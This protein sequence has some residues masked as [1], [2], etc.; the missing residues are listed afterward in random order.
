MCI[1]VT[2]PYKPASQ[3][4]KLISSTRKK[5]IIVG[6]KKKQTTKKKATMLNVKKAKK[7]TTKNTT[8]LPARKNVVPQKLDQN[9]IFLL[10]NLKRF[11]RKCIWKLLF[12]ALF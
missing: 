8:K 9:M 11:N 7:A 6:V 2:V 3:T 4:K 10:Q 1:L 5:K 12:F